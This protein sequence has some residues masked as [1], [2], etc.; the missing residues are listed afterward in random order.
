VSVLTKN[1]RKYVQ[2]ECLDKNDTSFGQ[3]LHKKNQ[4]KEQSYK[5]NSIFALVKVGNYFFELENYN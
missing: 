4:A 2:I 1:S 5:K 3:K